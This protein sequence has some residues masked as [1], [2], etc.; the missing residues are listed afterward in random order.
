VHCESSC[1]I[2]SK[3]FFHP[4]HPLPDRRKILN[5]IA[6]KICIV[7]TTLSLAGCGVSTVNSALEKGAEPLSTDE[8]YSLANNNTL[9]L[10]SSDFDAHVFLAEN[11]NLTANSLS[12]TDDKGIWD[13]KKNGSLCLKFN[14][15][16]YGDVKCYSI[17]KETDKSSYLFYSE[18]GAFAY[19]VTTTNGNSK[20]LRL[21]PPKEDNEY[22]RES[23]GKGQGSSASRTQPAVT[24]VP[25]I[26]ETGPA[27]S[28]EEINQTVKNMARD[29]PGCNLKDADLRQANLVGANLQ[30]AN[31][32]GVDLSRANLRRANLEGANLSGA[33]MLSTN[34]PGANLKNADLTGADLS[35]SN[36]IQAD[37]T[38]AELDNSIF[39]NTL[40]EGSKGLR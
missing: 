9:H 39:K 5:T 10:V 23:L 28:T 2:F 19:T 32:Q 21:A 20:H 8:I 16:Y 14:T 4:K 33:T 26:D 1:G 22:V 40:Q 30:G 36:L 37:F 11:G 27:S 24:T 34:L 12:N 3:S 29:C 38:G 13:I 18:N 25:V 17:Y 31:L 7:L 15:W 35:G 6:A